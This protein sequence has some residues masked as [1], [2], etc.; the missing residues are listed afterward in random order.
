MK[1][2]KKNKSKDNKS[3]EKMIIK[4]KEETINEILKDEKKKR[5]SQKY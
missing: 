2:Q 5:K 4:V 3:G 1:S